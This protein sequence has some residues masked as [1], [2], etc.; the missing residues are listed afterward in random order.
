MGCSTGAESEEIMSKTLEQVVEDIKSIKGESDI[1]TAVVEAFGD[2]EFEGVTD[3]ILSSPEEMNSFRPGEGVHS[4]Y[5][6][7][8]DAP[9]VKFIL[10]GGEDVYSVSDAWEV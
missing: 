1:Y 7:H 9:I 6:N 3:I 5:A 4:A 8:K 2:Y 10:T